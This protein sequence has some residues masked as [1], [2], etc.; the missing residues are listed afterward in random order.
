[1][2]RWLPNATF[3][4]GWDHALRIAAHAAD[5]AA[6]ESA[7]VRLTVCSTYLVDA[8]LN[9]ERGRES[10][11]DRGLA[12]AR[13]LICGDPEL[14]PFSNEIKEAILHH[15]GET[16]CSACRFRESFLVHDSDT[17]DRLGFT[18]IATTIKYGL[19][20]GRPFA[21]VEDPFCL[22]RNPQLDSCTLDYLRYLRR[23][24]GAVHSERAKQIAAAKLEEWERY[25]ALLQDH[26]AAGRELSI[27]FAEATLA[28]LR[29]GA[30]PAGRLP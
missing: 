23:L 19:W 1:M 12:I 16:D 7:R 10:H 15:E 27:E 30:M 4:H 24:H 9:L 21:L 14:Q 29:A 3:G 28:G 8:G 22:E 17:L 5:L 20:V 18:G 11:I 6:H 13:E 25:M 2:P 26:H